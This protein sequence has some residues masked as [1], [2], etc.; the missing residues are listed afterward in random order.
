MQSAP[1]VLAA[2]TTLRVG[3]PV[4]ELVAAESERELIAAVQRADAAGTPL[5]VLGGGSNL[6]AA[7]T[8]FEGLVVRGAR[9]G[10]RADTGAEVSVSVPAGQPWDEVVHTAVVE[11]WTGLEALS[12][13]PGSTGATPVQNVG[14]YGQEVADTLSTVR[15]YDRLEG[16]LRTLG[17]PELGLGYRT[18]ILKRSRTEETD[19][20]GRSWGV[21]GR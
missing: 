21:T 17:A 15:V 7:D 11:G 4:D 8:P 12:G 3:G 19:A 14:A 10:V 9:R 5:L 6:L 13:I 20:E 18:S 2:L 1:E 16:R